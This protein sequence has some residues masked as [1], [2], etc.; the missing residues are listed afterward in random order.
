MS[1]TITNPQQTINNP[2]NPKTYIIYYTSII[3]F[4][5]RKSYLI[6]GRILL[7]P[8]MFPFSFILTIRKLHALQKYYFKTSPV[9][10]KSVCSLQQGHLLSIVLMPSSFVIV[11]LFNFF[12]STIYLSNQEIAPLHSELPASPRHNPSFLQL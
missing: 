1:S 8:K 12:T 11:I 2:S 6:F 3:P 9:L 7:M 10:T 5:K 4:W